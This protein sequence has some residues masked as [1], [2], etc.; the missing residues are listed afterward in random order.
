MM[1]VSLL[2]IEDDHDLRKGIAAYFRDMG[3]AILEASDGKEG[4]KTF[5]R[6]RPDI[7]FTD[8]RM[9]VL[10]GFAVI[11]E[12]AQQSPDTPVI[13]ISGTGVISDAIQAM[14][15][16]AKDYVVKPIH[17]MEELELVVKRALAECSLR[18]EVDSL[19]LKLLDRPAKTHRAFSSITTQAPPMLAVLHYLEVV[20]TTSQPVLISG[21]TGVGKELIAEAIHAISARKGPYVAVNVAGLDDQMFSD[22]LFGHT[23]GAFTGADRTREGMLAQARGGTLF[24]DEIG[25]LNES[26]QIKLLRLLQEGEYYPLGSDL[27][28][29]S[30]ARI[31][32]A[33][34]RNLRA[35]VESGGFRKDLYYRLATHQVI[36]PPLRDRHGDIPLLLDRFLDDAAVEM[37]KKKPTPPPELCS[38]L[39]SYH[40]PGNIRELR[41]MAFDAVAQHSQG[42]LSMNSFLKAIGRE[43]ENR[44][45]VVPENDASVVLRDAAGERIPTLKEAEETLISDALKRAK[46]NQGIA[47]G[48]LGISRH[49]L[50]KKLI[51]GKDKIS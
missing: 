45:P 8:L 16:G 6:E 38:Y 20:A 48:Y 7:V 5:E 25:D 4:I 49:A 34:H 28:R 21:E 32:V 50:N 10:D 12:I 30:D 15:L 29:K 36:V 44:T 47:A 14:R 43:R 18:R 1:D 13:V 2:I 41:A 27:P 39:D 51:R 37:T 24:L 35:M 31:V 26:S 19:K 23:R 9:P 46:G 33:T 22:T 3:Y 17:E 11:R 42:V 40:F